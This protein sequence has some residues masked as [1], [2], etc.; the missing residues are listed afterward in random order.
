[1][2]T[3]ENGLF[4]SFEGP[5]CAG[6]STQTKLLSDYLTEK[7]YDVLLTREPGGTYIGE[8]IRNLVK[9]VV[10][11]AAPEPESELLLFSASRAQLV[12][13]VIEP[14]L[15]NGGIVICDRF[16]DSTTAYQ[17]YARGFDLQTIY[18]LHDIAVCGH[19]PQ[20]TILL[21]LD[22]EESRHRHAN[23]DE[24]KGIQDRFEDEQ[25]EFHKKVRAGFL[26]IAKHNPER[27]LV[28]QADQDINII[29]DK[30]KDAV[31]NAIA[32]L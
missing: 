15:K 29:H 11:D 12:R 8:E 28:I 16:A 21:D 18:R 27:F 22:A 7:N 30:I 19:W 13:K 5:E 2:A 6:K 9:H 4:I 17:G 25:I 24:T 1:M 32:E 20:L 23:R 3:I 14:Q 10:G 31:D 26:D